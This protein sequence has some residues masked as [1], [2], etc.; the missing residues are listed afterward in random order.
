MCSGLLVREMLR[1]VVPLLAVKP[2][3]FTVRSFIRVT[4]SPSVRVVPL[5]SLVGVVSSSS[6]FVLLSASAHDWISGSR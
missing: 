4:E 6:S 1:T 2:A 3:P 5:L